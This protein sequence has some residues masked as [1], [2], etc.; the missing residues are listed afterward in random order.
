MEME[1][2]RY[3]GHSMSD[4]GTTYRTRE[5]VAAVRKTRDPITMFK[6]KIIGKNLTTADAIK[7]SV[8]SG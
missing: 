4:P 8:L 5:E 7:V 6:E 1:T 3:Y 2:Y